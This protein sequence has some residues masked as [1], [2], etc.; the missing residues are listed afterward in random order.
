MLDAAKEA[1]DLS[2]GKSRYDIENERVLN[3]SLVRLIEVVGEA[4]NRVSTEGRDKYTDIPWPQIIGM[5]NRL[6]HGYDS[7]DFDILYQTVVEDLPLLI[8][9]LEKIVLPEGTP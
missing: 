1:V 4:A 6:V 5:R 9:E 8:A 7:I 3:L 2:S